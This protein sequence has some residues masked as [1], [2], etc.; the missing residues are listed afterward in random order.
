MFFSDY[1]LFAIC[2]VFWFVYLPLMR[3]PV[4]EFY[5]NRPILARKIEK[6]AD[7]CGFCGAFGLK[8]ALFRMF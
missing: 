3:G 6:M 5:K 4:S 7:F 8:I 2:N 1:K